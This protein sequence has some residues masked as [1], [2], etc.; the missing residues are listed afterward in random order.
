MVFAAWE[1]LGYPYNLLEVSKMIKGH[2]PY[3][4][5]CTTCLRDN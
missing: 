1:N 4:T 5:S 2:R 3:I